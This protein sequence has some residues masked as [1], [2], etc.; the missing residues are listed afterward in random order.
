MDI[1]PIYE[2]KSRLR[3]AAIAGTN[4]L[5]E[6]FRL[7]KAAESF[8]ALAGS[9]PVFAKINEMTGKLLES[10]RPEDLLD[11]ITLVDAVITTLAAVGTSEEIE[12]IEIEGNSSAIVTAPYSQLSPL[13]E[14]LTTKGSGN[15]NTFLTIK[16]DFPE[17]MNDYRVKPVLVKG[18]NASYSELALEV[19]KTICKMGKDMLPLLKKDF[20][21]KGKKDMLRRVN[22]IESITGADENDFYL[23]QL[24]IAEKDVRTALI[25]ALR[26]DE[27]N[28][29]R[30]I[31][32][33]KTEKG[34]QKTAALNALAKFDCEKSAAFFE[35]YAKKKPVEVIGVM[36]QVSSKWSGELTAR[37]IEELLVD[38]KGEKLTLSQ[39]AD[40]KHV[41]LKAKTDFY[42]LNAALW[43]KWGENIEKIYREYEDKDK[44]PQMS[45]RLGDSIIVT[46]NESLKALA[47]ELNN[48]S[49]L[50]GHYD[51]A[52]TVARLLGKEDSTDWFKKKAHELKLKSALDDKAVHNSFFTRVLRMVEFKDGKHVLSVSHLDDTTE[53][54]VYFTAPITQS[55]H[56]LT[57]ILIKSSSEFYNTA[58]AKWIDPNNKELC[59]KLGNYYVEQFMKKPDTYLLN[60]IR[61]TDKRNVKGLARAYFNLSSSISQWGGRNFFNQLPG[62][63]DFKLAEAREIIELARKGKLKAKFD[64]DDFSAWVEAGM[65]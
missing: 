48:K 26:H 25:Y 41:K 57:D 22:A 54:W 45:V 30:L 16:D 17:L 35:E 61:K 65:K 28:I 60:L 55:I 13:L 5:S 32:L 43:G 24:E 47:I 8:A 27:R 6:D 56:A 63:D 58:M 40:V 53:M 49:K 34:K 12:P 38:D 42:E 20:D 59:G 18:L 7:K 36:N 50:K 21:P 44:T 14:A 23:E 51:Y 2:L 33:T 3:A 37:L 1:T 46:G 31:E 62:D 64:V 19:E 4:L 11:T 52:E 15:Y 39:A 29:D 10:G 9:S